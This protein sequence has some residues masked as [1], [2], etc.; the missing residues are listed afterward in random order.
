MSKGTT[1]RQARQNKTYQKEKEKER[2]RE[3]DEPCEPSPPYAHE[4]VGSTL[5]SQNSGVDNGRK[6]KKRKAQERQGRTRQTKEG[7]AAGRDGQ[8]E[9][10]APSYF[11]TRHYSRKRVPLCMFDERT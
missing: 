8:R 6:G 5:Q 2:D 7:V 3:R 1:A 11:R 4:V 9:K 10:P